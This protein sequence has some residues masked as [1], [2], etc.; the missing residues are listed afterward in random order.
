MILPVIAATTLAVTTHRELNANNYAGVY[1][2]A[3]GL[4]AAEEID[5]LIHTSNGWQAYK[6][7]A[8][9]AQV[10]TATITQMT[11]PGYL[12]YG[13]LKDATGAAT[14]LDAYL[15]QSPGGA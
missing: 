1:V 2:V 3:N 6:N 13:F 4:A 15:Q 9:T 8:G 10:L 7:A 5:I 11:L 14:T 12:R